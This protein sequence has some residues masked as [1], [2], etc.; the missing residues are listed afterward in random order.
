MSATRIHSNSLALLSLAGSAVLGACYTPADDLDEEGRIGSIEQALESASEPQRHRDEPPEFSGEQWAILESLSP[1]PELPPDTTNQ[2]ADSRHAQELGQRLFFDEGFAGPLQVASD[3]GAVGE[4]GK[5]SC[6]SCHSG[7]FMADERSVPPNVSLGTNFHT[8]N[9]PA[10]VNSSFYQWTNWGG[11]FSAQWEL[12]LA[13]VESGIIM[14]G[15]RLQLA[16]RIFDQYRRSYEKVF[17]PLDRAIGSD[18]VRFPAAGKPKANATDPDGAW[19]RMAAADRDIVNR[20]LVNYA[21]ALGAYFRV[22][23]SRNAPFDDFIAGDDCAM[24]PAEQRG[25]QLFIGKAR[26]VGCHSSPDFSDDRFH[27]LGVPQ[28]GEHVP[29]IDAG[30]FGNV[31]ALLNSPFNSASVYSDDPAE[32]QRRL[33]GLTIPMPD[34]TLGAFRTAGLRG[35]AETAPYMHSGQFS[36]LAEVVEFYDQG[37]GVP[38]TGTKNPRLAP[39]GL[40]SD[41]KADLVLFLEVLSGERVPRKL[42]RASH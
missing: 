38:A 25:A 7:K 19:E 31:T 34:A 36:T 17:A 9:A 14:N 22:L 40:T 41:E 21:K 5:V 29:T 10:I 28:T 24:S 33:A 4:V 2:Y 23:V 37:G 16:H 15:N 1:L 18:L 20:I 30:R 27:N 35:V 6:A 39:L 3:L 11:R 26:C 42:V 12:P 8:R 13:V 32:G